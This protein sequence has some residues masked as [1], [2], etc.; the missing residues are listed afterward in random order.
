M[1]LKYKYPYVTK[2]YKGRASTIKVDF[3]DIRDDDNAALKHLV[4][5]WLK[6]PLIGFH[7]VITKKGDTIFNAIHTIPMVNYVTTTQKIVQAEWSKVDIPHGLYDIYTTVQPKALP[8]E[9]IILRK[10][11]MEVL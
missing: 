7:L 6:Q 11:L 5:Y 3:D 1:A 4:T 8:N 9:R 10:D 2:V